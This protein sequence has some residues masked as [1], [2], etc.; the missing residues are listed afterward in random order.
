MPGVG[1]D[2]VGRVYLYPDPASAPHAD[3][4]GS[5]PN[6]TPADSNRTAKPHRYS[7][8]H[9]HGDASAGILRASRLPAA[10]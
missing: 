7:Y 6:D 5:N 1:R 9:R 3:S 10:D 4:A 8:G 2:N